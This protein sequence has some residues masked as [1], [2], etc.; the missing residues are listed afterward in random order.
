MRVLMII[1]DTRR[2]FLALTVSFGL[3]CGLKAQSEGQDKLSKQEKS[4]LSLRKA[5]SFLV[6]G[7][8]ETAEFFLKEAGRVQGMDA[9]IKQRFRALSFFMEKKYAQS[10][11]I[12]K[13]SR[14]QRPV[15]FKE[16]CLQKLVTMMMVGDMEDFQ[17]NFERCSN[18]NRRTS[19]TD[20]LWMDSLKKF[21]DKR[22][23]IDRQGYD[24]PLLENMLAIWMKLALYLGEENIVLD[25]I[26]RLPQEQ[27]E[28]SI[29]RELLALLYYR[30]GNDEMAG[31]FAES[32]ESAN[33]DNI[34]GR[35]ALKKKD[36][37]NAFNYF[38]SALEKRPNSQNAFEGVLPLTW[39]LGKWQE[40]AELLEKYYPENLKQDIRKQA[41][42]IGF[43][44]K[45]GRFD[46]AETSMR[47]LKSLLSKR[48]L[49]RL[50]LKVP[51]IIPVMHE[52]IA[53]MRGEEREFSKSATAAC[54]EFDGISCWFVHQQMLWRDFSQI[55]Q[56]KKNASQEISLNLDSLKKKEKTVPLQEEIFIEQK[57]IEKLDGLL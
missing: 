26:D 38:K 36:Y 8:L 47:I 51:K 4:H 25:N 54:R 6:I 48:P 32:I 50:N 1:N 34:K 37:K 42:A 17:A 35:L 53:L 23:V 11:D 49:K 9:L 16:I 43:D 2:F 5:K 15:Y 44:I 21:I 57:E 29:I 7:D 28:S 27:Y 18:L 30:V 45:L 31:R 52:F 3:C 41:L 24:M 20:Q 46:R 40:G 12:L 55:V 33:G 56:K 13:D 22:A 10:L 19:K 39:I 14:F